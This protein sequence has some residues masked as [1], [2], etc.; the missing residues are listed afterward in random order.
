MLEGPSSFLRLMGDP[1]SPFFPFSFDLYPCPTIALQ[2]LPRKTSPNMISITG[3]E[4]AFYT[5]SVTAGIQLSS[6]NKKADR[7]SPE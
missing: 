2:H 6:R 4:A 1:Y 5:G 3:L 7:E